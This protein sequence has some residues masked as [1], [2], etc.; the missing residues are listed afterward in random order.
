MTRP[1]ENQDSKNIHHFGRKY[2]ARDKNLN[3]FYAHMIFRD[4]APTLWKLLRLREA[5]VYHLVI[6]DGWNQRSGAG[7][8]PIS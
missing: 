1:V 4:I 7:V 6:S 8:E 5:F 3:L 2:V